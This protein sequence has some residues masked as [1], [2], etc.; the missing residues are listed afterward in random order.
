MSLFHIYRNKCLINIDLILFLHAIREDAI[1]KNL[2]DR[3]SDKDKLMH[4]YREEVMQTATDCV[5]YTGI[6]TNTI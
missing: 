4:V 1:L 2:N 6:T 5:I 3:M